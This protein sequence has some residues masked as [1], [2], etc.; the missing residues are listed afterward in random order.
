MRPIRRANKERDIDFVGVM[1]RKGH[2]LKRFRANHQWIVGRRIRHDL[3]TVKTVFAKV[4]G[5]RSVGHVDALAGIVGRRAHMFEDSIV[6]IA[7]NSGRELMAAADRKHRDLRGQNHLLPVSCQRVVPA[8][9]PLVP[10]RHR[11]AVEN[12]KRHLI[13]CVFKASH[14]ARSERI[15]REPIDRHDLHAEGLVKLR[16]RRLEPRD[17]EIMLLNLVVGEFL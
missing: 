2:G 12:R 13:D 11:A 6:H 9:M 7:I 17:V 14:R 16:E 3:R 10:P 1:I 5:R 15:S 8:V 4:I